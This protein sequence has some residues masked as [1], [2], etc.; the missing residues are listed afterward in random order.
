MCLQLIG[1]WEE[2]TAK[3]KASKEPIVAYK[4]LTNRGQSPFQGRR[5]P[6]FQWEF[7]NNTC[8]RT[9]A[10]VYSVEK[11]TKQVG[12]GLYLFLEPPMSCG[13]TRVELDTRGCHCKQLV[14][15]WPYTKVFKCEID[16][17]KIVAVGSSLH[18]D[19]VIDSVVATEVNLISELTTEEHRVL[20]YYI[21]K[22]I[23]R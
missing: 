7:G 22:D 12:R 13:C 5:D 11:H 17:A 1:N 14:F 6:I 8:E 19:P 9:E 4:I 2:R 18:S 21:E 16:P 20:P 15:R 10:F 3:L 23:R